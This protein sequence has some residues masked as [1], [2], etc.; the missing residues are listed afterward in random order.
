MPLPSHERWYLAFAFML[1]AGLM[2][3]QSA[4]GRFAWYVPLPLI[5]FGL[6]LILLPTNWTGAMALGMVGFGA[7]FLFMGALSTG[8][9]DTC[10]SIRS[11]K[12]ERRATGISVSRSDDP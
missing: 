5:L 12:H 3:F 2:C 4:K 10:A 9:R 1:L 6:L 7:Q 11:H 8:L